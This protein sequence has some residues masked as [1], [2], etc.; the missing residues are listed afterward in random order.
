[1]ALAAGYLPGIH[2]TFSE[3]CRMGEGMEGTC[4]WY[5]RKGRERQFWRFTGAEEDE[6]KKD[7]EKKEAAT[8]KR[9]RPHKLLWSMFLMAAFL[10]LCIVNLC[11][12]DSSQHSFPAEPIEDEET[13]GNFWKRFMTNWSKLV[14]DPF[15]LKSIV[16]I[17]ALSISLNR[18]F[19]GIAA[20]MA[21]KAASAK[22][23]GVRFTGA[24]EDKEK[25]EAAP[26]RSA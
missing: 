17:L 11:A 18:H 26:A 14:G 10:I 2:S 25:K 6:E 13:T 15:M 8:A 1:M 22:V 5:G 12:K 23:G 4:L 7:E 9:I 19:K 24:E 20:G 21:G 16:V 3:E